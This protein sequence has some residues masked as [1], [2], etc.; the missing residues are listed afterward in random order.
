[1]REGGDIH[2]RVYEKTEGYE[3]IYILGWRTRS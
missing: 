3:R 1:M 2:I